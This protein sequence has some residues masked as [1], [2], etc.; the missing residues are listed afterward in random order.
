MKVNIKFLNLIRENFNVFVTEHFINFFPN[1]S[2]FLWFWIETVVAHFQWMKFFI[3]L[4]DPDLPFVQ[5]VR[6]H[7]KIYFEPAPEMI[8]LKFYHQ[9]RGPYYDDNWPCLCPWVLLQYWHYTVDNFLLCR[10]LKS[11]LDGLVIH[12]LCDIRIHP[13]RSSTSPG[14]LFSEQ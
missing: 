14:P 3:F 1:F 12:I 10:H 8:F 11:W 7:V 4:I 9:L 5:F 6:H 13:H 2:R